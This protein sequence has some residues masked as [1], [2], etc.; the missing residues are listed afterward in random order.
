MLIGGAVFAA[1]VAVGFMLTP[2]LASE[3]LRVEAEDRLADLMGARV[4]IG[5][6]HLAL[7]FGLRLEGTDVVSWRDEEG[8]PAIVV[9]RIRTSVRLTSL[10]FGRLRFGRILL[11][12]ARLR[13]E[14]DAQGQWS[15]APLVARV[16]RPPAAAG[17][18]SP[19]PEELLGPLIRIEN[20]VRAVLGRRPVADLLELRNGTIVF[21]DARAEHPLAPPLYLTLESVRARFRRGRLTGTNRLTIKARVVDARGERGTLE[22]EGSRD[23]RGAIRVAVAVTD[24]QLGALAPY[25]RALHPEARVEGSLSGAV[26]FDTRSPGHGRIEVDLVGHRLRTVEPRDHASSVAVDK[27]SAIGTLEITPQAVRLQGARLRGGEFQ[28][29][30]DGTVARPLR[31]SSFAQVALAFRDVEVSEVRHLIGWLPEVERDEAEKI[32]EVIESGR[33]HSLRAGG[34]AT[35]SAWQAF[36]AGRT[37][38]PPADFILDATLA[39][40]V[41]AV[42]DDDRLENLEGRLWWSGNRAE[43]QG[44]RATLNGSPLPIFDVSVENVTNFLAGDPE[45][46]HLVSGGV[47]LVGLRT[48]WEWFQ[49]DPDAADPPPVRMA[50]GLGIERLH[51]P[52]FLWPIENSS[53]V[54]WDTDR[55]LH[56]VTNGGTWAGVPVSGVGD[57]TF[58]PEER[59]A[60]KLV[61]QPPEPAGATPPPSRGWAEGSIAIGV[62]QE[63]PW[64]QQ[65]ATGRFSAHRGVFRFDD[66]EIP[67]QPRG[68]VTGTIELELGLE[69]AAPFELNFA[70]EDGSVAA[71]AEQLGQPPEIG[72]GNVD[73]SGALRGVLRPGRPFVE[74][75]TGLLDVRATDGTIRRAIPA[76]LAV[77]LAS[78]AFNPFARRESIRYER[79][80]T[81]LEFKDGR[82]STEGFLLDGPDVRVF[83]AGEL[84]LLRPPHTVD[85]QVA[86]F[87]FRQIDKILS[88][89]PIVNILLLG[90]DDNLVGA[91]FHLEGA[92]DNPRA[93]AVPLR[94]LASG[95]A[96]I[97]EQGPASLVLQSIPMFMLRGVQAIES[98]LGL[99]DVAPDTH[100]RKDE[101]VPQPS[102]S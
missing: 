40:T 66:V 74:D 8:T 31:A 93:T 49:S 100:V 83:A 94:A 25:V 2:R 57:W 52:M 26:V 15:P 43:V 35:I 97:I 1:A 78:A 90:T 76:V 95:P 22:W 53:V 63:G 44:V 23:R 89:I 5:E 30:I 17:A 32:V 79:G 28:L 3:S 47:P 33:L 71:L 77:A 62:L 37:R 48:V 9:D 84:D 6:V 59:V 82:M 91:H 11:D 27:I 13:I 29:E 88:K 16:S 4:S 99:R 80:E 18:G 70:L 54:I 7:G 72:S 69:D 101:R 98:M 10:L 42:G 20:T 50:L 64:S 21:V 65:H 86:L 38:T 60:I 34:A 67:L 68:H 55:G 56:I 81:L 61:A 36:L 73:L 14:R 96:S 87:L 51:H 85:A 24:L 12:G 92:W 41:V 75:L 19:H 46:R 45:R 102:E 58:A 39:D